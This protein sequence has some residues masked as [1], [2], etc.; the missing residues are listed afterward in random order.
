MEKLLYHGATWGM[1]VIDIESGRTL[2][3][4]NPDRHFFIASVRKVF[5]VGELM[6]KV[7]PWHRYTR[8]CTGKG[9]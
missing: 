1:R 5:T 3:D 9:R 6:D 4:L 2:I 8:L 7:G